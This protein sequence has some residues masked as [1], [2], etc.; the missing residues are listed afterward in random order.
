[1]INRTVTASLLV[2]ALAFAGAIFIILELD[3]PYSGLIG[4][5]SRP[6]LDAGAV[7]GH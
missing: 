5:S 3:T 4:V 7:L 1:V 6:L 2:C